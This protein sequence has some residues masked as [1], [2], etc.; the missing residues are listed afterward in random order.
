MSAAKVVPGTE[1]EFAGTYQFWFARGLVR[2]QMEAAGMPAESHK[3]L[4]DT[5][6][7]LLWML[8][9]C[10]QWTPSFPKDFVLPLD[11]DA[12]QRE[13]RGGM[14]SFKIRFRGIPGERSRRRGGKGT[15]WGRDVQITRVLELAES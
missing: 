9:M 6:D 15:H 14:R 3:I 1:A 8:T 2:E 10:E 12:A 11:K 13:Q 4:V 5:G 7:K